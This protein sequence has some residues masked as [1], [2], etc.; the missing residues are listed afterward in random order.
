MN[1]NFKKCVNAKS[2][3]ELVSIIAEEYLD[4]GLTKDELFKAGRRGIEKTHKNHETSN[5]FLFNAF[6]VWW[7][8]QAMLAAIESKK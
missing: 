5:G 1:N 7:V 2:D 8:R 4:K 3:K 6:A